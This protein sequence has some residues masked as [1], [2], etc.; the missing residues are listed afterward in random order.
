MS[1]NSY[2]VL[3]RVLD[4]YDPAGWAIEFGVYTGTSLRLIAE[5]MPVIGLDSF[6]GLPEDW[7]DGFEKGKFRRPAPPAPLNSMLVKGWFDDTVPM[8]ARRGLP[9]LGL[10]HIDCDLYSSTRTALHGVG[11][12]ISRD[13][14][15]VFDEFRGYPGWENHEAKAFDEWCESYGIEVEE[16]DSE[17][18]EAAFIVRS[19]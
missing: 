14:I 1:Q 5:Y 7:R 9:P 16:I 19:L 15:I 18:E 13:T 2:R 12:F 10:V 8:L 4:E 17:G 3:K 11:P 6:E